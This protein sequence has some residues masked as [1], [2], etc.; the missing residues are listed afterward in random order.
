VQ[1]STVLWECSVRSDLCGVG[2]AVMA[3]AG[4][5][6]VVNMVLLEEQSAS[7]E[8]R[9]TAK[10]SRLN[11]AHTVW[12][13]A[14]LRIGTVQHY[15][16]G[17]RKQQAE[18]LPASR[19]MQDSAMQYSAMQCSTVQYSTVQCSTVQWYLVLNSTVHHNAGR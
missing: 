9:R 10:L 8:P 4:A 14:K 3:E 18:G 16:D 13:H 1:R 15:G 7:G 5:Y 6:G 19:P 17:S 12:N 11:Q 2:T